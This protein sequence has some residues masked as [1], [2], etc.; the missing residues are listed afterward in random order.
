MF[1][2]LECWKKNRVVLT[3]N[4]LSEAKECELFV[5]IVS[6]NDQSGGK[7]DSSILKG[8]KTKMKPNE[9][10]HCLNRF[11][12]LYLC[13]RFIYFIFKSQSTWSEFDSYVNHLY[14]WFSFIKSFVFL[15]SKPAPR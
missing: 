10:G 4:S 5:I 8:S 1:E 2:I 6:V 13:E 7:I 12:K 11:K 15:R 3:L 14:V 9:N